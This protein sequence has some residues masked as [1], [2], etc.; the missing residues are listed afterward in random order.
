MECRQLCEQPV[1]SGLLYPLALRTDLCAC[2]I[3]YAV[4]S[5][6]KCYSASFLP[7]TFSLPRSPDKPSAPSTWL[8]FYYRTLH[9]QFS[10][11]Y[12]GTLE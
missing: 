3:A 2:A 7:L 9:T 6:L 11:A 4:G 8:A 1:V 10:A 12:G 5:A